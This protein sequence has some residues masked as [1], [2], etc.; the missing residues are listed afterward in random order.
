MLVY[1]LRP[2][3]LASIL[4]VVLGFVYYRQRP[5]PS[6]PDLPRLNTIEGEWF[7]TLR[8]KIRSTLNYKETIHQAY[9]QVCASHLSHRVSP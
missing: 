7:A 6:L 1:L 9:Q 5:K 4:I 8:A 2:Y 3:V